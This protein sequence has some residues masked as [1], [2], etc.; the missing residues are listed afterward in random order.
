MGIPIHSKSMSV[1][2]LMEYLELLLSS[3]WKVT[4][5]MGLSHV[6]EWKFMVSQYLSRVVSQ[7]V[8]FV[9]ILHDRNLIVQLS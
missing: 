3:C 2:W 8:A 4:P 5:T 1:H 6:C 7:P 9:A